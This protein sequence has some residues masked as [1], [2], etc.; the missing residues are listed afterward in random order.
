M[1]SQP[2]MAAAKSKKKKSDSPAPS[3]PPVSAAKAAEPE[4]AP[5]TR[6]MSL[7]ALRGFDMFWII[8][9]A[10]FVEAIARAI[11]PEFGDKIAFLTEHPEWN[12]Y[13][14]YDQIFPLFM[15]IAGAAIPFS[16]VKRLEEGES[17]SALYWKVIRRGLLLVLFGMIYN[18]LLRFDFEH[19]RYPSVLGR[20]GLSYMFAALIVLN[21]KVRGQ[22]IWIAGILIGYWAA[23]RF[24]HVPGFGAGDWSKGNTLSGYIDRILIPGELY[25]KRYDNDL[26]KLIDW[27]DPEGLFS[28]IPSIATVLSGVLAGHWLRHSKRT[29]E[30]TA[31]TL[32]AAGVAC[33]A[34][35][36]ICHVY[37]MPINKNLWSSSFVIYTTGWSCIALAISYLLIDVHGF[38][39]L[40]FPFVVIGMNAITIYM[41][42][43]FTDFPAIFE[44]VFGRGKHIIHPALW[45]G[46]EVFLA[47]TFLYVLYRKRIFL[48]V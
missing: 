43:E 32:F 45:A 10:G 24:I 4:P 39:K 38:K 14:A 28:T 37:V 6:L 13:T 3:A 23:M 1:E 46:G 33:V 22:V 47:W 44:L 35:A 19:Q 18:G 30:G 20:I 25:I 7:D 17:K 11:K 2:P 16:L 40:A 8:G 41:V 12:G 5:S 26:K 29:G 42:R 36:R 34:A 15:F 48:R 27:R 21:T 31:I 9:G